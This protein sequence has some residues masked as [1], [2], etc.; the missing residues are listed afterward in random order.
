MVFAPFP[1]P[2]V[3]WRVPQV[4]QFLAP[5]RNHTWKLSSSQTTTMRHWCW[6]RVVPESIPTGGNR[7]GCCTRYL[8]LYVVTGRTTC[9]RS[10]CQ[11][12]PL[13]PCPEKV[14]FSRDMCPLACDCVEVR[15]AMG[16][17]L[18]VADQCTQQPHVGI[19]RCCIVYQPYL[20]LY[21]Q[22]VHSCCDCYWG[23]S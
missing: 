3:L 12:H 1:T 19:I 11:R 18:K 2:G 21:I 15:A 23:R 6:E 17:G 13:G 14:R 20:T 16:Q 10:R 9:M 7:T 8:L 22:D 5:G 4:L